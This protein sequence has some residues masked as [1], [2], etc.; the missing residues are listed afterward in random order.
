LVPELDEIRF[1]AE[2]VDEDAPVRADQG[3]LQIRE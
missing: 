3:E 1:I 2:L